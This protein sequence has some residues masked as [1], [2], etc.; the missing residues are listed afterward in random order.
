MAKNNYSDEVLT[1]FLKKEISMDF[2]DAVNDDCGE[3]LLHCT[4]HNTCHGDG[5]SFD[6]DS[7]Y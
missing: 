6:L 7:V 2:I 1:G 3:M 5:N 4:I